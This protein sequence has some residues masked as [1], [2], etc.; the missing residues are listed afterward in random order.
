VKRLRFVV[1]ETIKEGKEVAT[2]RNGVG[3]RLK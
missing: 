1:E 3:V 2:K